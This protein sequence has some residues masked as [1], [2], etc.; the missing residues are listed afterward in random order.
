MGIMCCANY[1]PVITGTTQII[2]SL[3]YLPIDLKSEALLIGKVIVIDGTVVHPNQ[4]AVHINV[5]ITSIATASQ[6]L[7]TARAKIIL[8]TT[9]IAQGSTVMTLKTQ[10][11]SAAIIYNVGIFTTT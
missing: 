3:W 6:P 10:I 4:E 2:G 8:P 9:V 7:V 1:V 11:M 5:M